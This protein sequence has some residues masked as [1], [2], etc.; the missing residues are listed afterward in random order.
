MTDRKKERKKHTNKQKT[1]KTKTDRQT[2]RL[3][4]QY[5]ERFWLLFEYSLFTLRSTTDV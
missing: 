5:D 1:N 4:Q 2:D 3:P